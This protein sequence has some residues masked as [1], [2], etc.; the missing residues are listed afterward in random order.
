MV[1]V[2]ARTPNKIPA[3]AYI[4]FG[5]S[6]ID[7]IRIDTPFSRNLARYTPDAFTAIRRV[8]K[9]KGCPLGSAIV[10]KDRVYR[11]NKKLKQRYFD[12]YV[13]YI[14]V[15]ADSGQLDAKKYHI[16]GSLAAMERALLARA[17]RINVA[18]MN[19][20]IEFAPQDHLLELDIAA[21]KTYSRLARSGIRSVISVGDYTKTSKYH[22]CEFGWVS[23]VF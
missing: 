5:C 10:S 13:V 18:V 12:C 7:G 19:D 21:E 9:K 4:I 22:Q 8:M 3:D 16:I 15:R 6:Q 11:E 2:D 14:P 23:R 20:I 1:R 17:A